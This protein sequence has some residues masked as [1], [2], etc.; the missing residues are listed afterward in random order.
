MS[1]DPPLEERGVL[2]DN[3]TR[4]SVSPCRRFT[5][6]T[7]PANIPDDPERACVPNVQARAVVC[8]WD[9]LTG[10]SL[11]LLIED[12]VNAPYDDVYPL[13]ALCFPKRFMWSLCQ[14]AH[15]VE[16]FD[17]LVSHSSSLELLL[18]AVGTSGDNVPDLV[19]VSDVSDASVTLKEAHTPPFG[20]ALVVEILL[21][22]RHSTKDAEI[23][24]R[25]VNDGRMALQEASYAL[26]R[27]EEDEAIAEEQTALLRH[28]VSAACGVRHTEA[29]AAFV[30]AFR[31]LFS[32]V[33]VLTR[34]VH[35]L[36]WHHLM[37]AGAGGEFGLL[38]P[39]V[40]G[41]LSYAG[42]AE[43][44]SL[45]HDGRLHAA[46]WNPSYISD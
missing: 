7:L 4:L 15:T 25:A 37:V 31:K 26:A 21:K 33:N 40:H 38:Q 20:V 34:V 6:Y 17:V 41:Q 1:N 28:V 24:Q 42:C 29:G 19:D 43:P 35:P 39:V 22:L 9:V 16:T 8:A 44:L 14:M 45:P 32:V 13:S 11:Q 18:N 36:D 27:L 10:N 23:A 3:G 12:M 30:A 5:T 46:L 2:L